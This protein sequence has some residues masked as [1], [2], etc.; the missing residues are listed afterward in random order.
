MGGYEEI[1]GESGGRQEGLMRLLRRRRG[2][3][4]DVRT[5]LPSLGNGMAY[6]A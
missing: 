6:P 3:Q 2:A 5:R 1:S 4:G